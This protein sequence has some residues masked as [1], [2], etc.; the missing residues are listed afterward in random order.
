MAHILWLAKNTECWLLWNSKHHLLAHQVIRIVSELL[1]HIRLHTLIS[2]CI[3]LSI[4]LMLN[5]LQILLIFFWYPPARH[6]LWLVLLKCG[7][8]LET[9]LQIKESSVFETTIAHEIVKLVSCLDYVKIKNIIKTNYILLLQYTD[10]PVNIKIFEML[11]PLIKA[12]N[13][14]DLS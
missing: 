11:L 13:A 3:F 9:F 5:R 1:R 8:D 12:Y 10:I 14:N 7:L 6:N 4:L 2:F